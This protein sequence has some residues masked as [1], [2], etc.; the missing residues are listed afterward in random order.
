MGDFGWEGEPG[1]C[2]KWVEFGDVI[3][4]LHEVAGGCLEVVGLSGGGGRERRR[5]APLEST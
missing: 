4:L 2:P 3:L 1:L 5:R